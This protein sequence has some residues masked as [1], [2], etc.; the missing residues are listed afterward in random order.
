MPWDSWCNTHERNRRQG[1]TGRPRYRLSTWMKQKPHLEMSVE[2]GSMRGQIAEL[3][4]ERKHMRGCASEG[5]TAY[6]PLSPR[7]ALIGFALKSDQQWRRWRP[8][9]RRPRPTPL[10]P[11]PPPRP[12]PTPPPRLPTERGRPTSGYITAIA[13]CVT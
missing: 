11:P 3:K 2:A 12:P 8:R 7:H 5:S 1:F 4:C 10:L 6:R 9:R 13:M